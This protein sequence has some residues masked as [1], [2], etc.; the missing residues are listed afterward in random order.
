MTAL[1]LEK[2]EIDP[3]SLAAA[4]S[5]AEHE[6]RIAVYDLIEANQFHP[7]GAERGPFALRLG[8]VD[9]RLSLE[10]TGPDFSRSHLLSLT[11][12]RRVLKDYALVCESYYEAVRG[13]TPTQI[14]AIDMG[15]RGLHNDGAALVRERLAGKVEIDHE[16][17]R[18]LFTL[19][20]ALQLR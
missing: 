18:R 17:G 14:E 10:I 6:R 2:V 1:R 15:R 7:A 5:E 13:S 8:L 16:T 12:L 4:S 20:H 11:P 19:I 9:N 3:A